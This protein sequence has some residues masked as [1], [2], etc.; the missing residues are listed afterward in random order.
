MTDE[1]GLIESNLEIMRRIR[2]LGELVEGALGSC[3]AA[4]RSGLGM[5]RRATL[6]FP[7]VRA[8]T[9]AGVESPTFRFSE[10]GRFS[11]WKHAPP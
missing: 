1:V 9:R 11:Q 7:L 4:V 2:L 6:A 3:R 10:V 8:V 5:V